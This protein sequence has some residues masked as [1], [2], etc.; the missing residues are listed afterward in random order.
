[1]EA[2]DTGARIVALRERAAATLVRAYIGASGGG[3]DRDLLAANDA[4]EYVQRQHLL[5]MVEGNY[6]DDLDQLKALVEDQRRLEAEAASAEADAVALRD[7]VA[8]RQAEL[9]RQREAQGRVEAELRSRIVD[10][11]GKLAALDASEAELSAI[12]QSRTGSSSS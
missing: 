1:Q 10:F 12:I 7:E 8:A 2:A 4:N 5:G 6:Q 11:E 9:A 3:H